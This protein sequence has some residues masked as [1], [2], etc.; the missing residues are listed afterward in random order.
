MEKSSVFNFLKDAFVEKVPDST[1]QPAPVRTPTTAYVPPPPAALNS[2]QVP[3]DAKTLAKLEEKLASALPPAYAAFMEQ[4]ESLKDDLPDETT[5]FKVAL[6]TSKTSV[7]ELSQAL[8]HLLQIMANAQVEFERGYNQSR[9][10]SLS[11]IQTALTQ[12]EAMIVSLTQSLATQQ[13]LKEQEQSK[14]GAE[15]RRFDQ[16]LAGFNAAH[17]KVV[18]RLNAQKVHIG[19]QKV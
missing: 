11:Q 5:R 19:N 17:A 14:Q 7:G 6:K 8:D 2:A 18:A 13:A 16:I 10:E 1:A 9:S 15:T 3:V 4:Y 12:A